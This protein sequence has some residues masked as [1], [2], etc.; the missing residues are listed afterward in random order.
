M[1][2]AVKEG[3]IEIREVKG[4]CMKIMVRW[5][6][7]RDA[8]EWTERHQRKKTVMESKEMTRVKGRRNPSDVYRRRFVDQPWKTK[9]NSTSGHTLH[10]ALNHTLYISLYTTLTHDPL[11][12]L[13]RTHYYLSSQSHVCLSSPLSNFSLLTPYPMLFSCNLHITTY[14]SL[15]SRKF[16]KSFLFFPTLAGCSFPL[17]CYYFDTTGLPI[18]GGGFNEAIIVIKDPV[19]LYAS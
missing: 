19:I 10:C 1:H 8:V 14:C 3:W 4:Q 15:H 5:A 9:G 2:E 13:I 18:A 17:Q 6:E 7:N 11:L 16:Y 12:V